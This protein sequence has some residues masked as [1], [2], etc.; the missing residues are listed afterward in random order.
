MKG[1]ETPPIVEIAPKDK[2]FQT[3][4]SKSDYENVRQLG[5]EYRARV[6]RSVAD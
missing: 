4:L 3:T 5:F 2:A 6:P 1:I